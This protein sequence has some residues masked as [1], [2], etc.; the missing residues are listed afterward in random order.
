MA[1]KSVQHEKDR[2]W[3]GGAHRQVRLE[4]NLTGREDVRVVAGEVAEL[5]LPIVLG[6]D[7]EVPRQ[8]RR[9][10]NK[11]MNHRTRACNAMRG[12]YMPRM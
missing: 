1:V 5:V 7:E 10:T 6:G 11:E 4:L 9:P 2:R 8:H 3:D 12:T